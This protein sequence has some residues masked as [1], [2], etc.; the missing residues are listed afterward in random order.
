MATG[1]GP[2]AAAS[3]DS[4]A[5][6]RASDGSA[7][8]RDELIRHL[9]V[10]K[11]PLVDE[12]I[13]AH[14][15]D[16]DGNPVLRVNVAGASPPASFDRDALWVGPLRGPGRDYP[17]PTFVLSTMVHSIHGGDHLGFLQIV[18]RADTWADR[19]KDAL[20]FPGATGFTARLSS[21]QGDSLLLVPGAQESLPS[22][23]EPPPG[24]DETEDP[25]R[26]TGAI[27]R[28]GW[29]L[30]LAVDRDVLTIPVKELVWKF[31]YV[32]MALVVL[33]ILLMFFPRQFLLKPLSALQDAARRI[34]EGDFSARVRSTSHDE[35]GD[36]AGAFNF[37]ATAIEERTR[38]LKHSAEVLE[39]R[40]GD[41]R[42]ERDR[43]NAV[44]RSM[45]DGLFI[46][47]S[48]GRV[49]LSNAAARPVINA[50]SKSGSLT[51]RLQCRRRESD[52]IDCLHCI[53][54]FR[55]EVQGCVVTIDSRVYEINGTV[56]PGP[57][58]AIAGKVFVSR[59]VTARVRQSEQQAHQEHL[60][61]LGEIAAVM[62]HELN[63]PLAAISMFSQMLM[64]G[65]GARSGLRSHAEVIHRNTESCKATIRR[66]LDMATTST[67]EFEAFDVHQ[68]VLDVRQLLEPVARRVGVVVSTGTRAEDPIAF[69]D[70]LQL[71]QAAVNLVMN[72]IQAIGPGGQGE[73]VVETADRGDEVAILVRDN[74]PGIP[75]EIRE[76]IFE[77]F[78]TT[79]PPGDGTGLGL[80]TSRRLVD[81]Q[82]GSLNLVET[83][84][85]RTV[86]EI[87][88]PRRRS[89]RTTSSRTTQARDSARV[90]EAPGGAPRPS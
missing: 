36:L 6:A 66:L 25:I 23:G 43:L 17:F 63:N 49:A 41:I 34:A 52:V 44:I 57:K 40:E 7:I 42:F 85:G 20:A 59:D 84:P 75:Q 73:V 71:R 77:P 60:S 33:T 21:P 9:R 4:R 2:K 45:E 64:K 47:D 83:G 86:F 38:K 62:A 79:K 89:H 65:L 70:E 27:A 22:P 48:S 5:T 35:V 87:V 72:A 90:S 61:V 78:F 12:F 18:V 50:M 16:P 53:A 10:N 58:E 68:L 76:H 74:G 67:S 39:R 56:L 26:F 81:A 82:A 54:D 88:V 69:G 51:S 24:V 46:L 11:L 32:F 3:P 37:M 1:V 55:N 14:L 28:T 19:L 30:D 15:L 13:D 8:V 29:N 80:S 31:L